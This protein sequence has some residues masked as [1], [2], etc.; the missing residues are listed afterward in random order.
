MTADVIL[1]CFCDLPL[2]KCSLGIDLVLLIFPLAVAFER[3]SKWYHSFGLLVSIY[4]W[5]KIHL[6]STEH[7]R[8]WLF[9]IRMGKCTNLRLGKVSSCMHLTYMLILVGYLS[10]V[11]ENR[12]LKN[13]KD[14]IPIL[15]RSCVCFRKRSEEIGRWATFWPVASF[16]TCPCM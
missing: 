11:E 6:P 7:H 15:G 5:N 3:K 12:I 2:N 8:K 9:I 10:P 14:W 16:E 13:K 4:N 1:L